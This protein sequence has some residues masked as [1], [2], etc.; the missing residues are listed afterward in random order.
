MVD[1]RF[2]SLCFLFIIGYVNCWQP[3]SNNA[4]EVDLLQSYDRRHRPVRSESTTTQVQ[5]YLLISHVEEMV[6]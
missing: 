1:C 3:Q 6:D 2:S 4:L 5:V